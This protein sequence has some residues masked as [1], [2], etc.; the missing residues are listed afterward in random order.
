[1][2]PTGKTLAK[3]RNEMHYAWLSKAFLKETDSEA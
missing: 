1:M 3:A 2:K